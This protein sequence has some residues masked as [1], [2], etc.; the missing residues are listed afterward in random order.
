MS[1]KRPRP[2]KKP[3]T[4]TR[5]I[6][7]SEASNS[8]ASPVKGQRRLLTWLSNPSWQGLGALAGIAGV[9][10]AVV[11]IAPVSDWLSGGTRA[12]HAAGAQAT[13]Q[14][15]PIGSQASSSAAEPAASTNKT[16]AGNATAAGPKSKIAA[17]SAPTSGFLYPVNDGDNP[18]TSGCVK[19]EGA[20]TLD[21]QS[22]D[23]D[24]VTEG[25]LELHYS[26]RCGTTWGTATPIENAPQ[27]EKSGP[28]LFHIFTI[29]PFD[30]ATRDFTEVINGWME[31]S[32]SLHS[33]DRC[34]Y[35]VGYYSGPGWKSP[36]VRTGCYQGDLKVS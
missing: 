10:V 3:T 19:D 4:P 5:P 27:I 24:G 16:T 12:R 35:A 32:P 23:V 13:T 2:R 11:T 1:A 22:T 6:T 26:P 14:L 15:L 28:I 36:T 7:R 18:M 31:W 8:E 9:L 20:V 33:R 25:D 21:T 30:G 34:V 29:R 17:D